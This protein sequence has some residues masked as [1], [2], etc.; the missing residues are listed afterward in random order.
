MRVEIEGGK[1][2][3]SERNGECGWNVKKIIN[4]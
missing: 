3:G 2:E 1:D 4:K